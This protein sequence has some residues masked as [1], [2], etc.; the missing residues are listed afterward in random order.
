MNQDEIMGF[1][2]YTKPFLFVDSIESISDKAVVG[3]FKFD[4]SLDFYQGHLIN[5]PITPGVILI[6]TMAQIGL[7]CLGIYLSKDNISITTKVL[8]SSAKVDFLKPVF[9]NE[10]VTVFSEL[11]YF[12]FQK[13]RCKVK[14]EN[15]D[16]EVVCQ[17]IIDGFIINS[18]E[19][20]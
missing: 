5:F 8:M 2:P 3:T 4:A 1:L 15:E 12:R 13:L 17:G 16:R 7:V 14:M 18:Q 19:I 10:K 9:P 11:E 20:K 6:E